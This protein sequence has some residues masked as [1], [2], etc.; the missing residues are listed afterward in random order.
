MVE[1]G[2]GSTGLMI[3]ASVLVMITFIIIAIAIQYNISV[4]TLSYVILAVIF[5]LALG[6]MLPLLPK[7]PEIRARL[8]EFIP[9]FY[10]I[11]IAVG[12]FVWGY[13]TTTGVTAGVKQVEAMFL[14]LGTALLIGAIASAIIIAVVVV[15][16][17]RK[18]VY[19]KKLIS[20]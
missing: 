12:V 11:A 13:M 9:L 18:G 2:K 19:V 6:Y 17:M 5:T 1:E 3:S 14:D 16:M 15:Y 4:L 10:L 20:Y 7:K 8:T